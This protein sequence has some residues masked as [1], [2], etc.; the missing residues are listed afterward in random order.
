LLNFVK[1]G[2]KKTKITIINGGLFK[3]RPSQGKTNMALTRTFNQILDNNGTLSEQSPQRAHPEP[4]KRLVRGV[5]IAIGI[6]LCS[7][8]PAGQAMPATKLT[9]ARYSTFLVGELQTSCLFSIALK[10]SNINYKA[11]NR[12]SGASGAWQI[13]NI[14]V[15]LLT[16]LE[17]VEWAIRYANHRYGSPC[18]A[19]SYWQRNFNW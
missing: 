15:R 8:A 19:W 11:I 5:L 16:D 2:S 1:L 17:Q 3:T 13:M 14:K 6:S 10:E 9:P 12:S 7:A 18:E 4:L